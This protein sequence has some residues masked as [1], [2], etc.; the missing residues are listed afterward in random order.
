[1]KEIYAWVPWFQEL[2]GKIAEGGETYLAQAARKIAWRDD[3]KEQQLLRY[4]DENID[5]FSFFYSLAQ[6][7]QSPGSRELVFPS[8]DNEFKMERRPPV[9]SEDG[10][11]YPTPTRNVLFHDG[12]QG[13]P[14]LL[15][16]LF[17]AAVRGLDSVDPEDFN[18]ALKIRGVAKVN[19]TQALFLINPAQFVPCD[20]KITLSVRRPANSIG[21]ATGNGSREF[22]ACSRV[23]SPTKQIF[24]PI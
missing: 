12:G 2:A 3:G 13:N 16:K 20:D 21:D 6:R 19:L 14:K 9:E 24:L 15:W 23:V 7:T 22:A 11:V 5:P 18:G 10:F 8:I 4:G 1:M 17:R